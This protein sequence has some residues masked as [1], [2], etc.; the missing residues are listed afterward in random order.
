MFFF[1]WKWTHFFVFFAI[2][3]WFLNACSVCCWVVIITQVLNV[4]VCVCVWFAFKAR[5]TPS[6]RPPPLRV[7]DTSTN[8][9]FVFVL[10]QPEESKK[11]C[12]LRWWLWSRI[13]IW[14][15]LNLFV[16]VVEH[17]KAQRE[18]N[19]VRMFWLANQH[20]RSFSP[21]FGFEWPFHVLDDFADNRQTHDWHFC[22]CP[23]LLFL[24]Y[25][26]TLNLMK[27]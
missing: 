10:K 3:F 22:R 2:F 19:K 7:A 17:L 6:H 24:V 14:V 26:K 4:C 8:R 15:R 23:T 5:R 12:R 13:V 27:C 1:G 9:I 21:P 16:D 20:C 18:E 11:S 25:S